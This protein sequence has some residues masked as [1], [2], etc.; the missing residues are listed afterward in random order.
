MDGALES[1]KGPR[2]LLAAFLSDF[3]PA[4]LQKYKPKTIVIFSAHWETDDE[5][6]G[7]MALPGALVTIY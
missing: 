3:G 6:L 4:L 1:L 5:T 7:A 2:L